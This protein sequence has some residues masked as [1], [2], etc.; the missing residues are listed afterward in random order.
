MQR[1][2]ACRDERHADTRTAAAG[3]AHEQQRAAGPHPADGVLGHGNG[4]PLMRIEIA[5]RT[6][7]VEVGQGRIV[8]TGA[9]DHHVVDLLRQALEE[10]V[11][12]G[13][14]GRVEGRGAQRA[15]FGRGALQ[16]LGIAARQDDVGALGACPP[17]GLEP[18]AGAA[19]DHD[20]GLP[21]QFRFTL[22]G[23]DSGCGGHD[24]SGGWCGQRASLPRRVWDGRRRRGVALPLADM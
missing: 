21:G 9:G 20:D 6:L 5:V 11:E 13:R 3:A 16:A 10:L 8:R 7:A 17:G 23:R 14:V 18:D 4:Q 24:S 19:A 2:A 15:E 1:G 22:D 12:G